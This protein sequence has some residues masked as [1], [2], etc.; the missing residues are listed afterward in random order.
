MWEER[1]KRE[2]ITKTKKILLVPKFPNKGRK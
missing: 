2:E 1:N